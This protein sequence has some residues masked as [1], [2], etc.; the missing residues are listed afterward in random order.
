MQN[1]RTEFLQ[2][3]SDDTIQSNCNA[4]AF[5][6]SGAI[7]VTIDKFVLAPGAS[8][9]IDGNEQE[10]NIT[11]YRITFGGLTTGVLTVVRKYFS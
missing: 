6:N 9:S 3:T 2:Y 4:I 1:Y 7:P 5:I 10:K 8:L 11:S